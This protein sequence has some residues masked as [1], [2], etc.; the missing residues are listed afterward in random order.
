MANIFTRLYVAN[1]VASGSG[2]VWNKLSTTSDLVAPVLSLN[3]DI[4]T[5]TDDSGLATSFDILADGVVIGTAT[6]DTFDLSALGLDALCA[7][8]A[9]SKKDKWVDSEQSLPV[10]YSIGIENAIAFSSPSRFVL[11]LKEGLRGWDGVINYST[12]AS[13]WKAWDGSTAI[14]ADNGSLYLAGVGNT[15]ITGDNK[16]S[17]WELTGSNISCSGNIENL[18]DCASVANGKHPTMAEYCYYG[19]FWN[20]TGLTTAPELPATTL[21]TQCYFHMFD[22]CTSLVTAPKLPATTLAHSCYYYMFKGCTSLT[23]APDLPATT[24]ANYC[25][26]A[27]FQGCTSL[28][29]APE[30]PATTLAY[31][32]YVDMFNGCTSLT[33]AP[34]LPATTLADSCYDSMFYGCTGLTTAPELPATTLA[35]G[36]YHSMFYICRSLIT[37]P[38]LPATTL[39]SSCY[40][41]MFYGCT[42]LS[43]IPK[44][45]ATTLTNYCYYSMFQGCT[46]L[47]MSSSQTGDYQTAYRIP[48]SGTGTTESEFALMYMFTSTGGTFTGTPSINTTYYLHSSNSVA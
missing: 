13:D 38:E 39:T 44:L 45:P 29:T 27:M 10:I 7:I 17:Y 1:T 33:V 32:C 22:G 21:A 37:A 34:K 18:L 40:R 14:T 19:M 25:Y 11:A 15:V 12:D 23:M 36:C 4:L 35:N 5:I 6:S 26:G 8:S 3:G 48:T 46:S 31:D 9:I 41:E 42:S 20:C 24:L 30:L 28:T 43:T 2:R 47:K 16:S